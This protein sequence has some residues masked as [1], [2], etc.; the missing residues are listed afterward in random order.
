MSLSAAIQIWL[1]F[2]VSSRL[3]VFTPGL[4]RGEDGFELGQGRLQFFLEIRADNL[5]F[6]NLLHDLLVFSFEK[7]EEL[8]LVALELVKW[9]HIKKT[10]GSCKKNGDLLREGHRCGLGLLEYFHEADAALKLSL[11]RFVLISAADAGNREPNVDRRSDAGK[12]Q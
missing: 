5:L 1:L 6:V 8:L 10:A 3:S 9:V 11:R 12:K 2:C 4:L 7:G